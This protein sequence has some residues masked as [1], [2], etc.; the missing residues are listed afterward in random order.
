MTH[1]QIYDFDSL[2]NVSELINCLNPKVRR[3]GN[4]AVRKCAAPEKKK[5]RRCAEPEKK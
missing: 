4:G 3:R 5:V 2:G 1:E